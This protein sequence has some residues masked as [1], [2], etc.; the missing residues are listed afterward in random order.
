MNPDA[1]WGQGGSR[2]E[3]CCQM[4]LNWGHN[5]WKHQSAAEFIWLSIGDSIS[6]RNT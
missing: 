4:L 6:D 2:F 5:C 1:S 3:R